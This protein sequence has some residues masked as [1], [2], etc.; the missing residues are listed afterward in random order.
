MRQIGEDHTP[1]QAAALEA[2]VRHLEATVAE[3]SAAVERLTRGDRPGSGGRDG[4]GSAAGPGTAS[5]GGTG[6]TLVHA[7]MS[8]PEVLLGPDTPVR[9]AAR[10]LADNGCDSAPVTGAG[11]ELAGILTESDL[12]ADHFGTD[13]RG[14]ARGL[15]APPVPAAHRVGAAM[16]RAVVTAA[17]DDD[18]CE[19]SRRMVETRIRCVPVLRAG[20]VV[21]LVRRRDVVRLL[22]RP[23]EDVLADVRAA[24]GRS[25]PDAE[26]LEVSVRDGVVRV[27]GAADART[28]RGVEA[29][30]QTVPGVRSIVFAPPGGSV[31][32]DEPDRAAGSAGAV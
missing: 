1:P 21:G 24:I 29:L 7:M 31:R 12:L 2:R 32:R 10:L 20:A 17:E 13:D 14:Y 11:G 3:L 26:D 28:R 30:E 18:A 25:A 15:D 9:E 16:T 6:R 22:L 27:A 4:R 8:A 19:L 23:D 5:T